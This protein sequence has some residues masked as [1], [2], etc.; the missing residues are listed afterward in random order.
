VTA[1]VKG[2]AKRIIEDARGGDVVGASPEAVAQLWRD[3]SQ[4]RARLAAG[5]SGREWVRNNADYAELARQYMGNIA[6]L[7]GSD[8]CVPSREKIS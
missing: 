4:D 8:S 6:S 5:R 1:I 2:E 7:L 3:L